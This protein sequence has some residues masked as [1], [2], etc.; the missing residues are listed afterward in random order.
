MSNLLAPEWG[1]AAYRFSGPALSGEMGREA[2]TTRWY[3]TLMST[4]IAVLLVGL[5]VPLSTRLYWDVVG[6]AAGMVLG[7]VVVVDVVEWVTE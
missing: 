5:W 7:L 1:R 4:G 6:P 2:V 3:V